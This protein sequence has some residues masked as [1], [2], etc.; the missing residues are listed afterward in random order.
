MNDNNPSVP[1][2]SPVDVPTG[3]GEGMFGTGIEPSMAGDPH[4]YSECRGICIFI[5][6]HATIPFIKHTQVKSVVLLHSVDITV[7]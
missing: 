2:I 7:T 3:F 5:L 4:D 6:T 1:C